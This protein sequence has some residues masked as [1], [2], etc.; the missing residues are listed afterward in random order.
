M[1]FTF[2]ISKKKKAHNIYVLFHDDKN[3]LEFKVFTPMSILPNEWDESKNCPRNIYLKKSKEINERLNMLCIELSNFISERRKANKKISVRSISQLV[4]KICTRSAFDLPKNSLLSLI[5]D[6]IDSKEGMVCSSTIKRYH[7]FY[8]LLQRYEAYRHARLY[9]E[10]VNTDFVKGFMFFGKK[11]EYS[12]STLL[13]TIHFV[14]TVMIY[15][16]KK[17]ISTNIRE[18]EIPREKA[19]RHIVAL[20]QTEIKKILKTPVPSFLKPAKDWLLISCYTGQR[21]SDFMNF[22]KDKLLLVGDKY[23]ISFV[24]QKTGKKILLPLHPVVIKIMKENNCDF[25]PSVSIMQY[26]RQIKNIAKLAG[27]NDFIDARKRTGFRT[28][29]QKLEKWEV[30]SSHVGRRSFATNFYGKIPTSLLKD[31]TGH[32]SELMLLR[33]V[34]PIDD[35]R[36]VSLSQYFEKLYNE[37]FTT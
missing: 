5:R 26:N 33:Y 28:K 16:E 1:T 30:L 22:S 3:G 21:Y 11:E 6:Y 29:N 27:I 18:L 9:I 12:E 25:P 24:Q 20:S 36:V 13:K 34:N 19:Q 8:K 35:E 14:K 7:V 10:S 32:S 17:G 23:C 15:A 4:H 2:H 37:E 31:A